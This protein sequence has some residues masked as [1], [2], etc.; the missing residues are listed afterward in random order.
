MADNCKQALLLAAHRNGTASSS[1][2]ACACL[3]Q[4]GQAR[5]ET[6]EGT[7]VRGTGT[8]K[9]KSAVCCVYLCTFRHAAI[10]AGTCFVCTTAVDE[11]DT[12]CNTHTH[13]PKIMV[14]YTSHET[15]HSLPHAPRKRWFKPNP[16]DTTRRAPRDARQGIVTPA[17]DSFGGLDPTPKYTVPPS[18]ILLLTPTLNLTHD[19]DPIDLTLQ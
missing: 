11:F 9:D 13:A 17:E 16:T 4:R 18:A 1:L 15:S 3:F 6:K 12:A 10:H 7:K 8:G 5:E 2:R 14:R 19:P